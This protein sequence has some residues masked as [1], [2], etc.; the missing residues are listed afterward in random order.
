MPIEET[1]E[2]TTNHNL[3]WLGSGIS[4]KGVQPVERTFCYGRIS[5]HFN[6]I[7]GPGPYLRMINS[8]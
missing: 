1:N 5:T 3:I 6:H 2:V 8:L 7:D 4:P